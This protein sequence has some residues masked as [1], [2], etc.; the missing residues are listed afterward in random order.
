MVMGKF[1]E[2]LTLMLSETQDEVVA[3]RDLRC[4]M[5]RTERGRID[6]LFHETCVRWAD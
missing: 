1:S 6:I 2:L 4:Q 5:L 3:R